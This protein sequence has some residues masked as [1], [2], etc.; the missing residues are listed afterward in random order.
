MTLLWPAVIV[1]LF[2]A[3]T[4][5]VPD[6]APLVVAQTVNAPETLPENIVMD[7]LTQTARAVA[8]AEAAGAF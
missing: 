1:A 6:K 5:H 4:F 2:I 8:L 3:A 7:P